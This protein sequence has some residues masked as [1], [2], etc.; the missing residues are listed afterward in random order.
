MLAAVGDTGGGVA[1]LSFSGPGGG[2]W[3]R[4]AAVSGH[5][6]AVV[7]AADGSRRGGRTAAARTAVAAEAAAPDPPTAVAESG[8]EGP[9]GRRAL[10]PGVR[11]G[12]GLPGRRIARRRQRAR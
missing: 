5:A 7:A 10:G 12:H 3:R 6:T 1:E 9:G 11:I 8:G 4:T 2:R